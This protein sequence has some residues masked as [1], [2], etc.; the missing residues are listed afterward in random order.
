MAPEAQI[1]A[2]RHPLPVYS[3]SEGHLCW[4]WK[5]GLAQLE[6]DNLRNIASSTHGM[7]SKGGCRHTHNVA[8]IDTYCIFLLYGTIGEFKAGFVRIEAWK[9]KCTEDASLLAILLALVVVKIHK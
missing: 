1:C 8:L 9:I 6:S 4:K 7:G 3:N 5:F 2:E